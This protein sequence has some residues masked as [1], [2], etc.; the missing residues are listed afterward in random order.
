MH[1]PFGPGNLGLAVHDIV[2]AR[3]LEYVH[4]DANAV[5]PVQL[6]LHC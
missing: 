5:E 6:A 2:P 1:S 3:Q 4:D